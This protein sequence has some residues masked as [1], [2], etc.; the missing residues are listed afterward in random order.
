MAD[1]SNSFIGIV[2]DDKDPLGFGRVQVYIPSLDASLPSMLSGKSEFIFPGSDTDGSLDLATIKNLRTKCSWAFV[3]QPCFGGGA[4]GRMDEESGKT[5]TSDCAI[6]TEAFAFSGT[7][8]GAQS[9]GAKFTKYGARSDAFADPSK[10]FMR[11]GNIS[12]LDYFPENY[13]NAPKGMFSI[14]KLGTKVL[15]TFLNGNKN[16]CIITGKVPNAR[17][18]Q[19]IDL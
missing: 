17:E 15:V 13:I 6:D 5:T 19:L 8:S 11:R 4:M 18:Q 16:Q 14:P 7:T 3:Q 12:G 2:I 1:L 10:H 9:Y